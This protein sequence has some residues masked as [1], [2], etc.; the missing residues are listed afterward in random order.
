MSG[1]IIPARAVDRLSLNK[2]NNYTYLFDYFANDIK[3]A[4]LSIALLENPINGDPKP[5]TGCMSFV[6]DAKNALGFKEVGYDI[7]SLAGNHA[8]DGGQS[9]YSETIKLLE[10]Q[11]IGH[12]GTGKSD[13]DKLKPAIKEIDGYRVGMISADT[14]SS[15]YWYKGSSSYG[16]NW[17][18]NTMNNDIDYDRV[19]KIAQIK[20]DNNI[21]YMIAYMSWGVEY[22]NKATNFQTALAHAL[23]D[24]GVDL[25]VSSHPHWVQNIEFYKGKPIFYALGNFIFDQNH[26]DPTREGANLKLNYLDHRLKSLEIMPHMSCG[27]YITSNN[28]TDQYLQGNITMEELQNKNEK[29]GCVYFQAKR[30]KES[31]PFYK[32]VLDRMFQYSNVE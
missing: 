17:F 22:T 9:G 4:D 8:G 14:V 31:D 1:E 11:G 16:T 26:T 27:P 32:S 19:K 30:I 15:Y 7:F 24:N 28:I 10:A 6:G 2:N 18:S 29:T 23:I 5:C 21:D 25:V 13:A 3:S 12:T 20:T